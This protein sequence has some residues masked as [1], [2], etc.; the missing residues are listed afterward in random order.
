[1]IDIQVVNGQISL[2][3]EISFK[4]FIPTANTL[5]KVKCIPSY[6]SEINSLEDM[7]CDFLNKQSLS[8]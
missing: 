6:K 8:N 3:Q 2:K 1:M 5:V 7:I 4:L